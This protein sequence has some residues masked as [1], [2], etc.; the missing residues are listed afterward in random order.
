[1][2]RREHRPLQL[3]ERNRNNSDHLQNLEPYISQIYED[4]GQEAVQAIHNPLSNPLNTLRHR[5]RQR[6]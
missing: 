3:N 4:K 5:G 6:R 1:M 2:K